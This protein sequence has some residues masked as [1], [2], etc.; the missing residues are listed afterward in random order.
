MTSAAVLAK[1]QSFRVDFAERAVALELRP[2]GWV[3]NN[4]RAPVLIYRRVRLGDG[5]SDAAAAFEALF[6]GNGWPPDWRDSVYDY[7][8]YHSSAHEALGFAA[9]GARLTLGGPDG[10]EVEV[11]PGDV[12]VLPAG[13]GHCRIEASPD[14]LVVGAYPPGPRWDICRDAPTDESR[15]RMRLIPIP[16]TDPAAGASGP[17]VSRWRDAAA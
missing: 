17:L 12:V 13:T 9:G 16:A 14:F 4:R 6:G 11:G 7:H 1:A 3:P 8:H 15:E 2:N 10:L 5:T